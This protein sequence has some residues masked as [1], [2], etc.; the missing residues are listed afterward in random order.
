MLTISHRLR[1]QTSIDF[2]NYYL[3][4]YRASETARITSVAFAVTDV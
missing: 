4:I 3:A 1:Q 2:A